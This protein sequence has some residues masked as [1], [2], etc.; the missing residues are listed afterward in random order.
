MAVR[1][2]TTPTSNAGSF[3]PAPSARSRVEVEPADQEVSRLSSER[4]IRHSN[5]AN[6]ITVDEA[7]RV[8]RMELDGVPGIGS[9]WRMRRYGAGHAEAIADAHIVAADQ[10]AIEWYG[11][12]RASGGTHADAMHKV[13]TVHT[14]S[15][16]TVRESRPMPD[17]GTC[18]VWLV[19]CACGL[20][21]EQR[22]PN[23]YT[24]D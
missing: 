16:S 20:R 5:P 17:G 14:H 13:R 9:Y 19:S 11:S 4:R 24:G 2:K 6:P 3:A 10:M 8:A 18:D 7:D 1:A 12:V 22:L 21:E 15:Y 23:R